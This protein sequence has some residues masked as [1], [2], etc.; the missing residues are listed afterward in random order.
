MNTIIVDALPGDHISTVIK[1]MVDAVQK[2]TR[3]QKAVSQFNEVR[4]VATERDT[5]ESVEKQFERKIKAN[6]KAYRRST[7]RNRQK[8][9]EKETV[10]QLQGEGKA[11]I[12]KLKTVDKTNYESLLSWLTA[13]QPYSDRFGLKIPKYE[14]LQTLKQHGYQADE[15]TEENY[16]SEDKGNTARYLIGQCVDGLEKHRAI[17]PVL[18]NFH[19]EW[20]ERFVA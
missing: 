18:V 6:K 10:K 5:V 8:R 2:G 3:Y 1:E 9:K 16:N 19:K 13:F 11:L 17:H 20:K 4:I 15:N 12:Q 14:V 7:A